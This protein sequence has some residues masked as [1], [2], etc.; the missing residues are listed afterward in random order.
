MFPIWGNPPGQQNQNQQPMQ[1]YT[2]LRGFRS[3][4][5]APAVRA[6][7][8]PKAPAP[9]PYMAEDVDVY[10]NPY[11]GS[12]LRGYI[13]KVF[14]KVFDP[15]YFFN[16][17]TDAQKA[18]FEG[19]AQ[20]ISETLD[21][22]LRWSEW[23]GKI[24]SAET[25][26]ESMAAGQMGRETSEDGA[27]GE[28]L[29][30][31]A[32]I[33]KREVG[34]TV[35]AGLD[36][37]ALSSKLIK[38]GVSVMEGLEDIEKDSTVMADIS[39]FDEST[40]FGRIANM[41]IDLN[42][43]SQMWKWARVVNAGKSI[44]DIKANVDRSLAGSEM[45]YTQVWDVQKKEEFVRRYAAGENPDLLA[46]ELQ[47]PWVE[48]VGELVLDP[49]NLVGAKIPFTK[50]EL[51][52][53]GKLLGINVG[54]ARIANG[55]DEFFKVADEGLELAIRAGEK[56]ANDF[57]A[58]TTLRN[59]VTKV[60][61]TVSR[62]AANY[63]F[64]AYA[65]DAKADIMRKSVGTVMG[66]VFSASK[67][68]DESVEAMK[69]LRNMQ[70][71]DTRV[72]SEA[73]SYFAKSNLGVL[74]YSRAGV[75][76]SKFLADMFN[77]FDDIDGLVKRFGSD[78]AGLA[79]EVGKRVFST[80]DDAF[81]A[82][83][84]MRKAAQK[85]KD[86]G[87]TLDAAQ[88]LKSL[89]LTRA[90]ELAKK[91]N[92]LPNF[93]KTV[94]A[95]NQR[96]GRVYSPFVRFF[97]GVYMGYS[98]AYAFRNIWSNSIP[99]MADLG[100]FQAVRGTVKSIGGVS[101]GATERLVTKNFDN[102]KNLLG[103]V[104]GAAR[105]GIGQ[106]GIKNLSGFSAKWAGNSEQIF[107]SQ[108]VL[109]VARREI[110]KGLR[111]GVIPDIGML[112]SRGFSE[113]QSTRFI[114]LLMRSDIMGDSKKAIAILRSEMADG[115]V[116]IFRD[117]ALDPKFK[118]FL[119]KV[120]M[121]DE[122]EAI[123]HGAATGDEF[124][125]Q[126]TELLEKARSTAAKS[127][128][129]VA[130]VGENTLGNEAVVTLQEISKDILTEGEVNQ[131]TAIVEGWQQVRNKADAAFDA[132]FSEITSGLPPEIRRAFVEQSSQLK[133]GLN[134][135]SGAMSRFSTHFA[136]PLYKSGKPVAEMVAQAKFALKMPDNTIR[137][138]SLLEDTPNI[139]PDL[140]S[141]GEFNS[142]FWKWAKET[143][144]NFWRQWN[145]DYLEKSLGLLEKIGQET[146]QNLDE[147]SM[148]VFGNGATNLLDEARKAFD[149]VMEWQNKIDAT[150]FTTVTKGMAPGSTLAQLDLSKV[151][152]W[153]GG[154]SHVFN[155]INKDRLARGEEALSTINDVTLK[156]A[157]A[158][159]QKRLVPPLPE[160][161]QPTF[162]RALYENM[163]GFEQGMKRTVSDMLERWGET[164]P[165]G[166]T[167]EVME[168]GLSVFTKE[169]D[170][171]MTALRGRAAVVAGE[172]RDFILHDYNNTYADLA[173]GYLSPWH[174]WTN[175]TYM[176]WL[177]R[178][179]DKPSTVAMYAKW[180]KAM[181]RA[182]ADLPEWWRY[183]VKVSGLPGME[184]DH[185]LYFNLE[186]TLNPLNGITGVDF[187]DPAKRVD[188]MS[189]VVD[190]MGKYGMNLFT[191]FQWAMAM[192]LYAKGETDAAQR[193]M[194]RMLPQT[195]AIKGALTLAGVNLNAG[196][197][198]QNNE[199][200]PFVNLLQGGLDP[201]ERNR[202]AR[203]LAAMQAD[204]DITP[205]EA[206]DAG[207]S[208]SGAIWDEAV[209]MAVQERA[210]GQIA[211]FFMGVGFK[212]RTQNDIMT[213]KFYGEYY[214]LIASRDM[215]SP[216]DYRN[217]WDKLKDDYPFADTLLISRKGGAERDT[218]FAY[219]VLGR[220]PPGASAELSEFTG[221]DNDL[222]TKFYEKKGDMAG[223]SES[224]QQKFMGGILQLSAM[225]KLPALA[226][227]E[228]WNYAKDGYKA[229]NEE[230][231]VQFGPDIQEKIS[232]FYEIR[233]VS[234]DQAN[235]Y[236][237]QNPDV[238]AAMSYKKQ[239]I[240]NDPEVFKYYG[241]ID[242]IESYHIG[243]MYDE[244]KRRYG[245]D[246]QE[247]W[248]HY[249]DLQQQDALN[250]QMG[251]RTNLAREYKN[252]HPELTAYSRDKRALEDQ[253]NR[254]IVRFANMLPEQPDIELREGEIEAENAPTWGEIR[255]LMDPAL[256]QIVQNY[257][258]SGMEVPYNSMNQLD[259]IAG[260]NGLGTGD[261]LLRLAGISLSR[262]V[263][264]APGGWWQNLFP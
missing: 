61:D 196:P 14:A 238:S 200:D 100:V 163:E 90:V 39:G 169:L 78:T 6:G 252:E 170:T 180:K 105:R 235:E 133:Q 184:P 250:K 188:W 241:S 233:N 31:T 197:L 1:P 12:G 219:N 106:A 116:E 22:K 85:V 102:I 37:L 95:I 2:A 221:I 40:K 104:P 51:P 56:A 175:R 230:L 254:E 8:Q 131:F 108:I 29:A 110:E 223:W 260:Q 50:I 150:S 43:I 248:G 80:V 97:S 35:W 47:N 86:I 192:R 9:I 26:G 152:G 128:D 91:Y 103:F 216:E 165:I 30:Q 73:I 155:A 109:D 63:N 173:F 190:D 132:V 118:G 65:A 222:V 96:I 153:K 77:K 24:I 218:A 226:T 4:V 237:L 44:E 156:E 244:L 161:A 141:K 53:F 228:E 177:E 99:A 174:Y 17:K 145:Q 107:G 191:P 262:P 136:Y 212:G 231:K 27:L 83:E 20:E 111:N 41:L 167:D 124:V 60:T 59:V 227:R 181:E 249:Y 211:S 122:F 64:F 193:W 121:Y 205:E 11:Y 208:Q 166:G 3:P 207:N 18:T 71:K 142:L 204:G 120:G 186:A 264:S 229:I 87:K 198:V 81:P 243:K 202:V 92:E 168:E 257:W 253:A 255:R 139:A 32:G 115:A 36:F 7:P 69:Y 213:D 210:P 70:S 160:G 89:D 245:N 259:Y 76:T 247:K 10:G 206:I 94:N 251:R 240:M 72:L 67:G 225:L 19:K 256:Q 126:T 263:D 112:T 113:T 127:A 154:K 125:Q 234:V 182:N 28:G 93:I 171:R 74:P 158:A 45:I 119:S 217:A 147:V 75:E 239:Q 258:Q 34:Q 157:M 179:V 5:N 138:F 178:A 246:I 214:K 148:R 135:A 15:K 149:N 220:M 114:S 101:G 134:A 54:S 201:Y 48:L 79:E 189:S 199:L 21:T 49:L 224:D 236:M 143:Q 144:S 66:L 185:P 209:K 57:T 146:G 159:I 129:E 176:R 130:M 164:V 98:P 162:A 123:R 195:A 55:A 242:M 151:P 42:P 140:L 46:I 88:K 82:V 261:D 16:P 232:R 215:M 25:I 203:A 23:A 187:E 84:D 68:A 58:A 137:M 38:R 183:N 13:R 33:V 172:T 194:G 117:L 52:G 62:R